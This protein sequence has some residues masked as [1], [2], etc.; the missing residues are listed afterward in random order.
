M[1]RWRWYALAAILIFAVVWSVLCITVWHVPW[2][3]W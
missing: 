3:A 1:E 2:W